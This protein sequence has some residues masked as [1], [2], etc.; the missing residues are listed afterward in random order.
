MNFL[1]IFRKPKLS[2]DIKN[3]IL[4]NREGVLDTLAQSIKGSKGCPHLLMQKCP[5][6]FCEKFMQWFST[7]DKTGGKE[8]YWRCADIQTALFTVENNNILSDLTKAQIETN[9]LLGELV[10]CLKK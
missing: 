6:Q 5:G 1:T 3:R 10:N 2:G 9:K 4:K 7:N 8:E